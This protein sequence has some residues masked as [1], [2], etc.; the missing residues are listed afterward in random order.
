MSG[1]NGATGYC[2]QKGGGRFVAFVEKSGGETEKAM[3]SPHG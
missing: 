1:A 2:Q 3:A